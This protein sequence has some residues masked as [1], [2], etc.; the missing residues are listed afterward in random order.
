MLSLHDESHRVTTT[1]H[2]ARDWRA[3]ALTQELSL[4]LS[5]LCWIYDSRQDLSKHER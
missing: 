4:S 1:R 2:R 3:L 5:R